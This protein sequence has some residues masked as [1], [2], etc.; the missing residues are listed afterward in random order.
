MTNGIAA[1]LRHEGQECPSSLGI[2]RLTSFELFEIPGGEGAHLADGDGVESLDAVA[3]GQ[4]HV[5]ELGVHVFDIGEDE[6]LF[7][8][9]VVAHVAVL[10]GVRVPPLPGGLAEKGDVEEIRLRGVGEG[11]LLRGDFSR[12]QM[13]LDGV[14]VEPVVDLGEGAIEIPS[15][16]KAAVLVLLEPLEFLDEVDFKLGTDP[17]SKL[18]GYVLVGISAAVASS[19]G[20]QPNGIG[21]F[22]PFL[23]AQLVAVQSGLTF[24]YGEF[25]VIKIWVVNRFPNTKKFHGVAVS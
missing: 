10:A 24:N 20:S 12:N 7:E 13:G 4:G 5:N 19:R 9:G 21:L 15:E 17:H 8:A 14:G 3:L 16:R 11:G 23:N 25:A 22:Y 18:K 6:E 2:S 1:G